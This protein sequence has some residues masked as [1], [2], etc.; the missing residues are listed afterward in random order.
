MKG[1]IEK[2]YLSEE[3]AGMLQYLS[4]RMKMDKS[5]ILRDAFLEYVRTWQPVYQM[6]R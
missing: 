1:R 2:V 4:D 6:R 5:E 3:V